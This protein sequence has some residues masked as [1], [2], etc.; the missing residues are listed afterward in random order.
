MSVVESNARAYVGYEATNRFMDVLGRS[1]LFLDPPGHDRVRRLVARAF[2]PRSVEQLRPRVVEIVERQLDMA[3]PRARAEVLSDLA[4]PIPV[5]IIC[6]LLGVHESDRHLF[7]TWATDIAARFD[8]EPIRTPE[9]NKRGNEAA[10][11]LA[12]YLRGMIRDPTRR[13]PEG[14]V[15]RL[16]EVEEEGA[17]LTE[18]E[19]ISTSALLLMAGHETT[20][21]LIG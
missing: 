13:S 15:R 4:Y 8:I 17:R 1:M 6:D 7:P 14:L 16:L 2:T 20:A 12:D 11:A 9:I 21:N 10:G 3:E 5:A 19:V 18:D